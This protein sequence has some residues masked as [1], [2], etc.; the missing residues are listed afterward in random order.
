MLETQLNNNLNIIDLHIRLYYFECIL[1][2]GKLHP[3]LLNY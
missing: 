2:L 3:R 1:F